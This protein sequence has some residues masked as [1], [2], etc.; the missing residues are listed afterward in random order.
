MGI[1]G[2]MEMKDVE[3]LPESPFKKKVLD[4][5]ASFRQVKIDRDNMLLRFIIAKIPPDEYMSLVTNGYNS[6][7]NK[8]V[9]LGGDSFIRGGG[10]H[11]RQYG[12][13]TKAVDC[14]KITC[15]KHHRMFLEKIMELYADK[16]YVKECAR[17]IEHLPPFVLSYR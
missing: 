16:E 17:L 15:D 11:P 7:R 12:C 2:Y 8:I 14:G 5:Q 3:I 4:V 9:E 13:T 6:L 10:F 1:I